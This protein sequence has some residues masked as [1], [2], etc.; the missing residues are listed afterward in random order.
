MAV[1]GEVHPDRMLTNAGLRPG[2]VLILTKPL[3]IGVITTALEARR[4]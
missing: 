3:G 1:I 2:Q 4:H